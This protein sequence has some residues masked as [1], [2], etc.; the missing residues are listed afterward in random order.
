MKS[1]YEN[2]VEIAEK[3]EV[4]NEHM[5]GISFEEVAENYAQTKRFLR[6]LQSFKKELD[7]V[8]IVFTKWIEEENIIV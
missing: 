2:V 1:V 8:I 4:V 6:D 5:R 3:K 7:E